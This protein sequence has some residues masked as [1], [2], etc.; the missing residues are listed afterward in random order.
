VIAGGGA[1][2]LA[3]LALAA[4]AHGGAEPALSGAGRAYERIWDDLDRAAA[5]AADALPPPAEMAA[6]PLG[7]F[8]T[9]AERTPGPGELGP[10][11]MVLD[12][13]GAALVWSGPGLL[14]D[15][16]QGELPAEGATFTASFGAVTLF[17]VRP[18]EDARRPWRVVAA[19]SFTTDRLPAVASRLAPPPRAAWSVVADPEDAAA[20]VAVFE[21]PGKPSLVVDPGSPEA[22]PGTRAPVRLA[23]A[24]IGAALLALALMRGVGMALPAAAAPAPSPD[25]AALAALALGGLIAGGLAAAAPPWALAVLAGGG[26]LAAVAV[27]RTVGTPPGTAPGTVP[28]RAV[29]P[30]GPSSG[31]VPDP[32]RSDPDAVRDTALGTPTGGSGLELALRWV[33]PAWQAGALGAAAALALTCAAWALLG[34]DGGAVLGGVRGLDLGA[35]LF[36]EPARF[37]LRLAFAAAAFGLLLLAAGPAGARPAGSPP[38]AAGEP[39]ENDRVAWLAF[40]ALLAASAA[41][42]LPLAALPLLAAGA[43]AASVWLAGRG[44]AGGPATVAVALLAAV[45][46]AAGSWEAAYRI[47]LRAGLEAAVP[48]LTPPEP[49]ALAAWRSRSALRLTGIDLERVVPREPAGLER[50]DLAFV[51]WRGSPLA[52]ADAVSA[53]VVEPAAGAAA[54]FSFGLPL[55]PGGAPAA[56]A[57]ELTEAA[58]WPGASPPLAGEAELRQG[59]QPWGRLRWWLVPRPGFLLPGPAGPREIEVELLRGGPAGGLRPAGLPEPA[60]FALYAAGGQAL[61]S[62]W[63]ETPPLP[64]ALTGPVPSDGTGAAR[65]ARVRTPEGWAWGFSAWGGDAWAVAYLPLLGPLAGLERVGTHAAGSLLF[66]ALVSVLALA[67]A[68]PR[69]AFRDVLRRAVRSYS[70]RLLVVYTLL[71]LVPLLLLNLV[72]MAAVEERLRR[73]QRAA[74][75]AALE[76]A[77]R[78]VADL[79]ES[80]PPGF[81]LDT[82]LDNELLTR[83]SR[84]IRHEVNLYWRSAIYASS[85][86]DLF[87]AGLLPRRI[88]GDV[89]ARLAFRGFELASRTN[90]VG[91]ASYLELYSPLRVPGAPP[92]PGQLVLS[93]PLLAQQE[94]VARDLASLRRQSFLVTAALLALLTAVG[95]RLAR[96]FTRPLMEVVR[97]TGR[98]AAGATSLDVAPRDL[99]LAAL[100]SAVDAMARRIAEGREKLVREKQVV[101]R[102]VENITS[103]VVSLDAAGRVL[104]HNRVAAELLGVGEDEALAAALARREHLAPV[105][106]F[107]GEVAGDVAGQGGA[108]GGAG[109]RD[110]ATAPAGR[111]PGQPS[112]RTVRLPG[113]DGEERE[114]SLVWV[115][116]PGPGEPAALLVVEDATETLRGQRLQAWAEMARIIAHEIKNPLTPLRLNVEHLRQVWRDRFA[117]AAGVADDGDEGE[118]FAAVLDRCTANALA[119]VEELRQIATDFSTYS[120]IP[121][122]DPR[123]GDLAAAM[124]EL[125]E[126]YRA[127]PPPGVAVEFDARPEELPARFDRKL[128]GRAVRNLIENALRASAGGGTV[129]LSVEG[130]DGTARIAVADCGPGV[131]PELLGRIFHPYFSTHDSGTGLG[132]PIARQIAEEHGG[133]IHARN[134]S[135]GGLEVAITIPL[136]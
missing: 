106:E 72:L 68:L 110:G 37:V 130:A 105:A 62:P 43:G 117:P 66:T 107:V 64:E 108:A 48:A 125:A 54:T 132:L 46:L 19:R 74:G 134:R 26:A 93:V 29:T 69:P 101:E 98:I 38:I 35:A 129:R 30:A 80:L 4:A 84:V 55:G 2:L 102:M 97:G 33:R 136:P 39:P 41:H 128:L 31:T 12:P 118:R 116:V 14:H 25:G 104:M 73:E 60:L 6:E 124:R 18:L 123:P 70:K 57:D 10:S 75:E 86:A 65:R 22:V 5:G 7:V 79:L 61:V 53:L 122:I 15:P 120:S 131:A 87:A 27:L 81:G 77:Q 111:P 1:L 17:S 71:L 115:P 94:E 91:R 119:Q 89:H 78:Q 52:R 83:I 36:G 92:A 63:P 50:Q 56:T 13:D 23:W 114:W 11:L 113:D 96:N 135:G 34:R 32:G 45:L 20:G 24:L 67:L 112:A 47:R 8:A 133:A 44:G 95:V 40:A 51:L 42:D 103:G 76:S 21:F 82:S 16:R 59:G 28:G 109:G 121:R 49:S 58:G 126:A 100:V 99:E 88:P 85:K 90:R 9:L 3:V 127:A